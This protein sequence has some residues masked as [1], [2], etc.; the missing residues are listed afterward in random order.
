VR[1]HRGRS[2]RQRRP[3]QDR[4]RTAEGAAT[5]AIVVSQFDNCTQTLLIAADGSAVLGPGE[6]QIDNQLTAASW[7]ATIE[8]VDFVSGAS[9]PVDVNVSWTGVDGTTSAR[10]HTRQTLPGFKI[11]ERFDRTFRE[12]TASGTVS[13]GTTNFT[14]PARSR[15]RRRAGIRQAGGGGHHPPVAVV[16]IAVRHRSPSRCSA[17]DLLEG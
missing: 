2:P 15:W 7:T 13:D 10:T 11:N 17:P 12:A 3:L 5:A 14:P 9:F 4:D 8:V 16:A 6:V 1:E